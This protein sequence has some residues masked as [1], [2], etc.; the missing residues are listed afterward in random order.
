MKKVKGLKYKG[1]D[2]QIQRVKAKKAPKIEQL[3][4]EEI[5]NEKKR[6]T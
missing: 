5:K 3:S 1:T 4:E 6:Q 2:V